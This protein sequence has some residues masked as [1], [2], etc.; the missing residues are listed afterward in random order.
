MVLMLTTPSIANY[1]SLRELNVPLVLDKQFGATQVVDAQ[2]D[3][4]PACRWPTR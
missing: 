3:D 4:R 2:D 1:R